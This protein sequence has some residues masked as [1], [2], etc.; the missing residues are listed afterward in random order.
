M[1][2]PDDTT[3]NTA[4]AAA[5]AAQPAEV[6]PGA[7]PAAPNPFARNSTFNAG[8]GV[9]QMRRPDTPRRLKNGIRLRR[10]EG[11]D[12]LSWPADAWCGILLDGIVDGV[13]AEA[14]D[15][16]RAG[17]VASLQITP[18]GIE[19]TVQGRASR[20][21]AVRIAPVAISAADWDRVVSIMARE[22]VYSA[23]LLAGEMPPLV[24]Q[25]FVSLG[26]QLVPTDP[27]TV[28]RTCT[29][30][31]P[32]PCKHIGCVGALVTERLSGDPL[33][34]FT[35]R[36]LDGQRLL[37]RLQEARAIATRGVA[38][39]HSTPPAVERAPE[40]QPLERCIDSFWRPGRQI[41]A[42]SDE[43]EPFAPHALLRR[44]GQSPLQGK[45]P[46][47]GLLASIY[48]SI[49]ARGRELKD[50]AADAPAGRDEA[51]E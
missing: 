30:D 33:L 12:L 17:Q 8:P 28:T 3:R 20:P 41:D 16:A 32:K 35:L 25:P 47:V 31:L 11:I 1:S 19:A 43:T 38:R 15:Y 37:E 5:N 44:L 24:E 4:D 9:R 27:A 42:L 23:K 18:A 7:A 50:R 2:A 45:F 48:D 46:L 39:A 29:C 13:K 14:L 51:S 22:A 40:A 21:Y 36:G 10:R 34:A 6:A 26:Q 49:A